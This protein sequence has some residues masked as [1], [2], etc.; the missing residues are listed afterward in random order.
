MLER[1]KDKVLAGE[2]FSKDEAVELFKTDDIFS[3]G[4]LA[5]HVAE[6]KN[7]KKVFFIRNRHINPTNICVNR[8]RFCAFS[9]S[10]G[11][12]GAFELTIDE[13]IEK[14]QP[15]YIDVSN[16]PFTKGGKEGIQE[17]HIVGG[18]HPDRPFE[19]YLNMLSAIK[20]NFPALHIKAFTAVE[21]D[22]LSRISG[23]SLKETL[24]ALK[25][26][27]LDVM[28]GGGAEIFEGKV[29]AR[30]CPEKISGKRWL[31]VMETAHKLRIR[32]NATMLYGHIETYEDRVDHLFALRDLQDRTGGFQAFVPLSYHPKGNDVGGSFSSGI[33]DLRTIAVSR[34]VLDN[35]D[36]ITAYWIMLGEKISQLSLLFG[37]DD[38]SG[39]IIEEK[40]THSAGALSSESMT[41]EELS[42]LITMAGRLPVERDCFYRQVRELKVKR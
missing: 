29:R 16:P 39:T 34:V 26:H 41:P 35:F 10:K 19:Y 28:P 20:K 27:G 42:H 4:K 38:L 5:S 11:E 2:R 36:H 30:L 32:T 13:I 37:A 17:V 15:Y 6:Q 40:I 18:L 14:L 33:D 22:Y 7:G 8:C 9:R 12:E 25:V 1:M 23:L 24:Y 31:E 3:L 21:I